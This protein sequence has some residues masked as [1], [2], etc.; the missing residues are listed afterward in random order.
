MGEF[1]TIETQEQ[2]DA[3]I[4]DRLKRERETLAKK[5]EGYLSPEDFQ[6][7]TSEYDTQIGDLNKALKEA[8]D[9]I[10]GHDK[11]IAE[12]DKK[13]KA[14]ESSSVK[15][16]IAHEIGLSY[17]A[18]DF[19]RGET[20]EEIKKSAEALKNLVGTSK[21]A[22]PLASS[23]DSASNATDAALRQTLKNLKGE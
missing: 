13:I 12:R 21:Q 6:K 11:E 2:F 22:P 3:A 23:E 16:R 4:G 19:L 7:K 10:A 15:T 1:Q 17:D 20:E 14:Y 5:Y 8:D 9:K 18:V